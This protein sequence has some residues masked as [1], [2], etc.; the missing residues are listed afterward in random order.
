[1]EIKDALKEINKFSRRELKEDEVYIFDLVLCDND[2][3]RDME[4]FSD[5]ALKQLRQLFIGKTGIFDHDPKS[6]GQTARIFTTELITDENR[7]TKYGESY[8]YL[9]AC[10][11]MV[12]TAANEDLIREIDGGIKKEVSISCSAGRQLCSV[13]G[14][15]RRLKACPHIKGKS[16]KGKEA[17]IILDDIT[18]AYEWSF[19]A[20]PAQINAGVTK[21]FGG[22][23]EDE[24]I[25]SLETAHR[26]DEELIGELCAALREDVV[27]LCF[28]ESGGCRSKAMAA[29]ADKMDVR[30]LIS[31]KEEL[32]KE[33]RTKAVSQLSEDTAS[34][35]FESFR[36]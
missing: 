19:V 27:R 10:A 3:D 17:Y 20:V 36:V 22:Q 29:A 11:Y 23:D 24:R 25:K 35:S 16:Y 32:K 21:R 5:N 12:K 13:C 14:T 18:D 2:I 9:K 4:R 15:D 8:T 31:F 1:M 30:E 28:L 26:Q 6:S 34:D 7:K 33:C